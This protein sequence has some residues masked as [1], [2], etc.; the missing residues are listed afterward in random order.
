VT[1]APRNVKLELT[2]K[3]AKLVIHRMKRETLLLDRIAER[4]SRGQTEE[5]RSNKRRYRRIVEQVEMALTAA[6]REE[7][8]TLEVEEAA[9]PAL[10]P[11]WCTGNC[12]ADKR[13]RRIE[14]L[15][16]QLN[17]NEQEATGG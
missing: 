14:E 6:A 1:P 5:E 17:G 10:C 11:D 2:T 3:E 12:A 8:L 9:R 13:R 15:R 16:H 7:L 4:E